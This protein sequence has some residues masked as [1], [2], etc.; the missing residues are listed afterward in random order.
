MAEVRGDIKRRGKKRGFSLRPFPGRR[1]GYSANIYIGARDDWGPGGE[2][3]KKRGEEDSP[4]EYIKETGLRCKKEAFFFFLFAKQ[5][6]IEGGKE[7]DG[8]KI[9][10]RRER[11]R[12]RRKLF[13][14]PP[15]E[16]GEGGRQLIKYPTFAFSHPTLPAHSR[17]RRR[18]TFS[19]LFLRSF[20][21]DE[22][23]TLRKPI[24]HLPRRINV[25]MGWD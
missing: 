13:N 12:R 3:G 1:S 2:E 14:Q 19:P 10:L 15:S 21:T 6:C 11:R 18:K 17:K 7:S 9:R 25:H 20:S 22:N 4:K 24:S 23:A 5:K 8:I 16:R